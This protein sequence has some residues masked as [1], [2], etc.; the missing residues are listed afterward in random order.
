MDSNPTSELVNFRE[1]LLRLLRGEPDVQTALAALP[2]LAARERYLTSVFARIASKADA[3]AASALKIA[4][5]SIDPA[6]VAP[7]VTPRS[8]IVVSKGMNYTR[9]AEVIE[10]DGKAVTV[11]AATANLLR[12][13]MRSDLV[14]NTLDADQRAVEKLYRALPE[15][16]GLLIE[17][18]DRKSGAK[19]RRLYQVDRAIA[20][21][22]RAI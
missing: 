14:D 20:A 3:L 17:R 22:L 5:A 21:V 8:G 2:D 9:R 6:T 16:R 10:R 1:A 13:A 4:F 19:M 11:S 18:V 7:E 15:L 12:E